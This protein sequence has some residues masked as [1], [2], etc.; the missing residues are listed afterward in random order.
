MAFERS[1]ARRPLAH[2]LAFGVLYGVVLLSL[3]FAPDGPAWCEIGI[4]LA[5]AATSG[6]VIAFTIARPTTLLWRVRLGVYL[7]LMNVAYLRVAHVVTALYGGLASRDSWLQAADTALFGR[8]VPLYLERW[9]H[10]LLSDALSACYFLLF[11]YLVISVV[12][13][14]LA[15]RADSA[16]A[17]RFFAG[18]FTVYALGFLG[19]LLVPAA[20]AY[21]V[22]PGAFASPLVGGWMTHLNDSV[23]RHGSNR[24]DVFPSLHIAASAFMLF[25]DRRF[26][27]RRYCVYLIPAI[28]LWISTVY[29]RFHYGVDVLAGFALAA[30]GLW[31]A[32]RRDATDCPSSWSASR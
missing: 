1:A 10:P 30:F 29:L 31:V 22:M 17:C 12:R 19:Y 3:I 2:E 20:G 14:L 25:F 32:F 9:S 15:V 7:V 24:V 5:L 23:V 4:W 8:P 28:G 6:A 13:R 26:A 16:E 27:R 21:L 11:P 18:L